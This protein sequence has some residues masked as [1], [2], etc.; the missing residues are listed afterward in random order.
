MTRL[1]WELCFYKDGSLGFF[2]KTL[3]H[4]DLIG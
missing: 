2:S 3:C 4:S 1:S